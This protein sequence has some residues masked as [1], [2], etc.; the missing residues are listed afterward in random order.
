[1]SF[2]ISIY[3]FLLEVKRSNPQM[4]LEADYDGT[5]RYVRDHWNLYKQALVACIK[6]IHHSR[7][8][9]HCM[10]ETKTIDAARRM[11]GNRA[12]QACPSPASSM[13]PGNVPRSMASPTVCN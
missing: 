11:R 13:K 5:R 10:D 6:T 7:N 8:Y 4:E 12:S 1:M 2:E 9:H 3:G